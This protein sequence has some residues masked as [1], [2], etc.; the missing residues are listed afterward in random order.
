MDN[1]MNLL[2]KVSALIITFIY[3][4]VFSLT[5]YKI[6][7]L[8]LFTTK[9]LAIIIIIGII[10]C[11]LLLIMMLLKIKF[12]RIFAYILSLI[13]C[14]SFF[15]ISLQASGF[16]EFLDNQDVQ[17][18]TKSLEIVVL[19]N[20]NIRSVSDIK[21]I[22]IFAPVT[23]DI[24]NT[25]FVSDDI[26]KKYSFTPKYKDVKD[27]TTA[28]DNL[29]KNHAK[30][31]LI[32]HDSR[33]KINI[34]HKDFESKT[35]VIYS[36]DIDL[37]TNIEHQI[38]DVASE[39]FNVYISGDDQYGNLIDNGR[40]DV[41]I[42][43]T[44]NPKTKNILLTSIPRDYYV[45]LAIAD[46]NAYDKLTHASTLG[47]DTSIKT[48]ED[49]LN[50]DIS[51]YVRINFSSLVSLVDNIDGIEVDNP[52]EFNTYDIYDLGFE[53]K[54]GKQQLNGKQALA[55]S[56]ERYFFG[57]ERVRGMNQ[58]RVIQGIINKVTRPSIL[59]NFGTILSNL[60]RVY[61]T[62]MSKNEITSLI[63][64][65]LSNNT[66]WNIQS[67]SL[68]GDGVTGPY[69]YLI[70]GGNIFVLLPY[71]QSIDYAN[72]AINTIL[73]GKVLNIDMSYYEPA[74][75][76]FI[77]DENIKNG[78]YSQGNIIYS[79]NNI[80]DNNT[81]QYSP[82]NE[83]YNNIEYNN[84]ESTAFVDDLYNSLNTSEG[85]NSESTPNNESGNVTAIP[86]EDETIITNPDMDTNNN[87]GNQ[88][89]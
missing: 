51:Y 62:N 37:T 32:T 3:L 38:D 41:N 48:I 52:Q 75:P 76:I 53:F 78:G 15:W 9:H 73:D 85:D 18:K 47:L 29:L 11:I 19:K 26:N 66:S 80:D 79:N 45:K 23:S 77:N 39:P 50:I 68:N 16:N 30:A 86:P 54:V 87:F 81:H 14:C 63:K 22:N 35:R 44:V 43:A 12:L 2:P 21:N 84:N 20:S 56:R 59:A 70:P 61:E 25:K 28:A 27:Y 89:N 65:Q 55:Y 71:K 34:Q 8:N 13:I 64:Y 17:K 67:I 58:Q 5:I 33:S 31:I 83:S 72:K 4:I 60:G 1:K 88:D 74:N 24:S 10:L 7:S 40:S 69:S 49:L 46:K 6:Y 57:D 82:S 36:L 42:I